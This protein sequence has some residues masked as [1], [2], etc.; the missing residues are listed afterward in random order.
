MLRP[1]LQVPVLESSP[2]QA[3]LARNHVGLPVLLVEGDSPE[4]R[5]S[6]G[7]RRSSS[8]RSVP[9]VPPRHRATDRID[10]VPGP[11]AGADLT[12]DTGGFSV[13][14][15]LMDEAGLHIFDERVIERTFQLEGRFHRPGLLV[16]PHEWELGDR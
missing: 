14:V 8:R 4:R 3:G 10:P 15:R 2:N 1:V 7:F 6:Y 11:A 5:V 12:A 9:P 13:Q 16:V